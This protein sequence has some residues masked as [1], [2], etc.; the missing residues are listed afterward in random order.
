MHLKIDY[1]LYT[2]HDTGIFNKLQLN[3]FLKSISQEQHVHI[4]PLGWAEQQ[5]MPAGLRSVQSH[6]KTVD[7]R[8]YYPIRNVSEKNPKNHILSS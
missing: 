4:L 8:A 2:A 3:V 5:Q 7:S 6:T 1:F